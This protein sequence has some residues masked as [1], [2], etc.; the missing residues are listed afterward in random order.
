MS[1]TIRTAA[2]AVAASLALVPA[3]A[4]AAFAAAKPN[5]RACYDGNCKITITKKVSFPVDP[6]FGITR[7]TLSFK[8]GRVYVKDSGPGV[9]GSGYFDEGGS[10]TMNGILIYALSVSKKK[11]VLVLT[12]G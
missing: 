4:P 7:L 12:T 8:A 11:A 6:S 3:V 10:S 5:L 2:L 1:A 9:R